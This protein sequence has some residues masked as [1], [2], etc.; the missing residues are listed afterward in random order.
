M[1][2]PVASCIRHLEPAIDGLESTRPPVLH[3][4]HGCSVVLCHQQE[5]GLMV[6][7]M[8]L[9]ENMPPVVEP[10]CEQIANTSLAVFEWCRKEFLLV[11]RRME[12]RQEKS[13]ACSRLGERSELRQ[14]Q[15][16]PHYVPQDS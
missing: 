8:R 7:Q 10:F 15:L 2:V 11:Q 13:L 4:E 14:V 16:D 1:Q 9:N 12:D 3:F 5:V 6:Q